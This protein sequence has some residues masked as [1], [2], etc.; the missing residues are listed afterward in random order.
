[1]HTEDANIVVRDF[2]PGTGISVTIHR[3]GCECRSLYDAEEVVRVPAHED[4]HVCAGVIAQR[5]GLA[6]FDYSVSDCALF[7]EAPR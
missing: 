2:T 3:A 7:A 6:W 5:Y 4:A 1:M